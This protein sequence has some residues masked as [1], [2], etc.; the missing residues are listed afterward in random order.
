MKVYVQSLKYKQSHDGP[1]IILHK[2]MM[3][4]PLLALSKHKNTKYRARGMALEL[5]EHTACAEGVGLVPRTW[6]G[7]SL[8][9]VT[10]GP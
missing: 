7:G 9:P 2:V 5:G 3:V 8:T 6:V 4:C 10:Q 1:Y